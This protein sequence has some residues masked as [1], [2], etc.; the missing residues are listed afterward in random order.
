M[1]PTSNATNRS[2]AE[3]FVAARH[4]LDDRPTVPGTVRLYVDDAL[5]ILT[6]TVRRRLEAQ[7]AE[8]AVRPMVGVR[9][10]VND[11]VATEVVDAQGY[12]SPAGR[13]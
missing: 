6:G 7:E 10:L 9:R 2:N 13:S 5:V 1:V 3:T 11:I 12:E 4:A 8:E